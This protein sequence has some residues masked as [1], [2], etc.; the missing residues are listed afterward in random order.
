MQSEDEASFMDSNSDTDADDIEDLDWK[1]DE[2]SDV[3]HFKNHD[4]LSRIKF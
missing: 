2:E 1:D 4:D 3:S